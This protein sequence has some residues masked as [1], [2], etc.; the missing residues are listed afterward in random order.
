MALLL[1]YFKRPISILDE[2]SSLYPYKIFWDL[3]LALS[4]CLLGTLNS[5]KACDWKAH[6]KK[7]STT[8]FYYQKKKKK[9]HYLFIY[10]KIIL[11]VVKH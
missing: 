2:L 7:K 9:W 4:F 5:S 10:F 8:I 3:G 6:H 11:Q 1:F